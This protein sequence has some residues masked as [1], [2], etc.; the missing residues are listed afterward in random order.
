LLPEATE[1]LI[2]MDGKTSRRS[3]DGTVKALHLVL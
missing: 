3:H 2:A 1:R